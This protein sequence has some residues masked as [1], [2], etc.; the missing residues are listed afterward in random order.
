MINPF[1]LLKKKR[2]NSFSLLLLTAL[3]ISLL[4]YCENPVNV[5][6]GAF[7]EHAVDLQG[8]WAI[9]RVLRN[10]EDITSLLDFS[11]FQLNLSMDAQ[12]P[13]DFQLQNG[14]APFIV[15]QDGQW[16]YNDPVYPTAVSFTVG[17]E[18]ME[19][20]FY[21]PPISKDK[22]FSLTFS[23]GCQDNIYIYEFIKN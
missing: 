3:V 1:Y 15:L 20:D 2:S 9:Q 18:K 4:T 22:T 10:G 12:G 13:T 7:A 14:G 6:E 5:P 16:A 19:A 8:N 11:G 21:Q 17:G 23:L